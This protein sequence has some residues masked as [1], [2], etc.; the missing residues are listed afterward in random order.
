MHDDRPIDDASFG[1]SSLSSFQKTLDRAAA[2]PERRE[3]ALMPRI[4]MLI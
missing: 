3:A 2:A 4:G 1:T